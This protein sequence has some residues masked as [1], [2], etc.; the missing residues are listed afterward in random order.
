MSNNT[1]SRVEFVKTENGKF[2]IIPVTSPVA[3]LKGMLRKP[4]KPVSIEEMN[5]AIV[6]V[7]NA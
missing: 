6:S 7:K 2:A 5:L 1:G 4:A 3:S